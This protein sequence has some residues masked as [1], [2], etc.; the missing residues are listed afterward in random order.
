MQTRVLMELFGAA[1]T[2]DLDSLFYVV[3]GSLTAKP[4]FTT[5]ITAA[6]TMAPANL[7]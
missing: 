2:R 3:E 5:C 6:A 4:V 1:K 7:P